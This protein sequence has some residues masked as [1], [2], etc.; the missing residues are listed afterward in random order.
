MSAIENVT[1]D[2]LDDLSKNNYTL[3]QLR[4]SPQVRILRELIDDI[5]VESAKLSHIL[6][7]QHEYHERRRWSVFEV[8]RDRGLTAADDL[9][10]AYLAHVSR[11]EITT[12]PAGLRMA[13][14]GVRLA[15]EIAD[16]NPRGAAVLHA[17]ASWSAR[18][19]LEEEAH[20]EVAFGTLL[21]MAGLPPITD[22]EV[23]EWRG[24]FPED[25]YARVC[26]LQAC[27]EV[28]ALVSYGEMAKRSKDPL[29]REVSWR[30]MR[31]EVQH[32]Q[33]FISFARALIRAG[34]FPVKDV[35]AM[36][37]VWLRPGAG[38]TYG[39]AREQQS[40]RQGYVNWWELTDAELSKELRSDH[41]Q[42]RKTTSILLAIKEAT[43]VSV[44][45]F[46]ELERAYF[47]Q[48]RSR[49]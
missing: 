24:F 41:M 2:L 18:Y 49:T 33:Y 39:S 26:M 8:I 40:Q 31:D 21:E 44:R 3:S 14:E 13:I 6:R 9:D 28:E 34:L 37:Y 47:A 17:S 25:N 45:N 27:V 7:R 30:I 11:A 19:W 42:E 35:L 1:Q 43:G 46:E 20:H 48:L 32:R 5:P 10:R 15:R 12:Q 22:A 4:H 23:N 36:A 38:E 29:I 16:T